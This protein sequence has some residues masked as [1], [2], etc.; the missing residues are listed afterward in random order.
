MVATSLHIL[1]L[2]TFLPNKIRTHIHPLHCI[3]FIFLSTF[4]VYPPFL[5]PGN[6]KL[7]CFVSCVIAL[8]DDTTTIQSRWRISAKRIIVS[9]SRSSFPSSLLRLRVRH[10][11]RL[12]LLL[13]EHSSLIEVV[14]PAFSTVLLVLFQFPRTLCC[15]ALISRFQDASVIETREICISAFPAFLS[16]LAVRRRR[17]RALASAPR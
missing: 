17:L 15:S 6:L 1:S 14:N 9:S 16:R 12:L 3:R 4:L 11:K 8:L 2:H 7:H 5:Q 10:S 13:S